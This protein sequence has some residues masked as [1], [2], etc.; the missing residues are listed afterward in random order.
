M[1]RTNGALIDNAAT[2]EEIKMSR[3]RQGSSTDQRPGDKALGVRRCEDARDALVQCYKAFGTTK[4]QPPSSYL[5]KMI[6][7]VLHDLGADKEQKCTSEEWDTNVKRCT[8]AAISLATLLGKE[9]GQRLWNKS[10]QGHAQVRICFQGIKAA[11]RQE[12]QDMLQTAGIQ[13]TAAEWVRAGVSVRRRRREAPPTVSLTVCVQPNEQL[14]QILQGQMCVG[15][16]PIAT[17][18]I[19]EDDQYHGYTTLAR[20]Q[21][22]DSCRL[23]L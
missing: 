8:S 19:R 12:A 23:K 14:R 3:R 9:R 13:A 21:D 22:T 10:V 11:G 17:C 7:K 4:E 18:V 6:T 2:I 20:H 15:R 16:E 5:V 1:R